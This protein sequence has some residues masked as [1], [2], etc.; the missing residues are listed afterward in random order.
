MV[1]GA[2][3]LED[4]RSVP[5]QAQ[6]A[7]LVELLLGHAPPDAR[8]SMSSTRRAYPAPSLPD[9]SQES[10]AVRAFPRCSSPVGLGGIVLARIIV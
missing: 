8:L 2:P 7:E 6:P 1:S 9:Q 10:N 4:R 5:V 3:G